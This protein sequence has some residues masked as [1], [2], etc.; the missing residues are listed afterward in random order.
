VNPRFKN[1][2]LVESNALAYFAKNKHYSVEK[3]YNIC[4]RKKLTNSFLFVTRAIKLGLV[5]TSD[6]KVKC[7]S[8]LG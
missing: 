6:K 2:Y 8:K 1:T 4:P 5:Y 7:N 3:F